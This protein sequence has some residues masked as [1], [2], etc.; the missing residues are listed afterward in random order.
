MSNSITS[1][2]FHFDDHLVR[3]IQDGDSTWFHA[4][5]VMNALDYAATSRSSKVCAHIPEIWKGV[6]PIHTLGGTQSALFLQEQGLYFFL[7]RSDKPKALPFQMWVYGEVLPSI[8]KTGS[9]KVGQQQ[10]L[11]IDETAESIRRDSIGSIIERLTSRV[12]QSNT[13]PVEVFMPLVNAVLRKAGLDFVHRSG[14]SALPISFAQE[15]EDRLTS[16][17]RVFHPMTSPNFHDVIAIRRI[18]SGM[19]PKTGQKDSRCTAILPAK[20]PTLEPEVRRAN[21]RST[22]SP[23]ALPSPC[24]A[25]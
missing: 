17:G 1:S 4:G 19:D 6:K 7:G 3:L 24:S 15:L 18:L 10:E 14:H 16:L 12:Q 22:S 23:A 21:K 11:A 8:R 25:C 20:N 5:D 13:Y 2:N 9:Y